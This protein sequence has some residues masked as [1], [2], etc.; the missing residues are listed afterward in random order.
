M[1]GGLAIVMSVSVMR[2][3]TTTISSVMRFRMMSSSLVL[4]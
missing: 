4:I 2:P 3:I 1:A